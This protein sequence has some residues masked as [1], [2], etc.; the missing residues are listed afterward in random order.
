ISHSLLTTSFRALFS[1][2]TICSGQDE[3]VRSI[4]KSGREVTLLAGVQSAR[5]VSET[6]RAPSHS[7]IGDQ[8]CMNPVDP[9]LMGK[10]ILLCTMMERP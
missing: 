5:E 9:L 1:F 4:S 10:A 2:F 6:T 3:S 7:T 8:I